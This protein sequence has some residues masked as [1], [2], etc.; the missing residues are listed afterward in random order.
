MILGH[1]DVGDELL[2]EDVLA[3]GVIL[4]D[5]VPAVAGRKEPFSDIENCGSGPGAVGGGLE[6]FLVNHQDA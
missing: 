5:L 6:D 1:V 2:E 4:K 3:L